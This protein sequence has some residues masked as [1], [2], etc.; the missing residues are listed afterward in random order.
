[1]TRR[2]YLFEPL[3]GRRTLGRGLSHGIC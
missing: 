1:L 3:G 2:D